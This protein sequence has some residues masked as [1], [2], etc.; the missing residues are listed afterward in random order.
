MYL[1]TTEASTI[2]TAGGNDSITGV[3]VDAKAHTVYT[4]SGNDTIT[5]SNDSDDT[6]WGGNGNDIIDVGAVAGSDVL[7]LN[8]GVGKTK[9]TGFLIATDI[10]HLNMDLTTATTAS[11]GQ[12]VV[13]NPTAAT[14]ATDAA[15]DFTIGMADTGTIDVV[16]LEAADTNNRDGGDLFTDYTNDTAIELF[17]IMAVD[18]GTNIGSIT[19]DTAGDQF[20]I[21]AY[22]TNTQG[23]HLYHAN[24]AAVLSDTSVTINEMDYVA[25]FVAAADD[26]LAATGAT[27]LTFDFTTINAAY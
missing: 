26:V 23:A 15:Y 9:V 12:A 24:S 25:F 14:P 6:V 19:V 20:Y 18:N 13:G 1:T 16:E 22:D 8:A 17:K 11:A 2:T 10:L 4:Y 3:A 21:V 7:Y 5:L 27:V